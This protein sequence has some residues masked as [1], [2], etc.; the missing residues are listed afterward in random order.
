MG[1]QETVFLAFY[2]SLTNYEP[3]SSTFLVLFRGSL[4][5]LDSHELHEQSSV[6]GPV[7]FI[8]YTCA[9]IFILVN[10]LLVYVSTNLACGVGL[11]DGVISV[12]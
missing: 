8:L 9:M 10:T 12:S 1:N 6:M 3:I 4:G 7:F 5:R 11:L 2:R